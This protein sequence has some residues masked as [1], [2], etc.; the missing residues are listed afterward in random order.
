MSQVKDLVD[1]IDAFI[2]G[3]KDDAIWD[4]I[5]A[6]CIMA[7]WDGLTPI[8]VPLKGA[9]PT[10]NNFVSGDY[11]RKLGLDGDG[12]TKYL[13]TGRLCNDDPQNDNHISVYVTT[14]APGSAI[15]CT[16]TARTA[17]NKTSTLYRYASRANTLTF[18][19]SGSDGFA[20]IS[21]SSSASY[22]WRNGGT[23]GTINVTS[24]PTT[25]DE[26]LLWDE[27]GVSPFSNAVIS[28]YSIGE[29]L[30]LALLDTRVTS[31]MAQLA[32]AINTGLSPV[33]YSSETIDY[34]NA[35]YAAG[36]SL[37]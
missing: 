11:D 33:G 24:Q 22:V 18:G 26:Y 5:K 28:F 19:S 31:L 35:G 2:V 23:G 13:E 17:I 4:A 30:D 25:A 3:C 7:A 20:G 16:G 9:A 32:F 29:A 1:A 8:E 37:A 14:T 12:A 34:V 15:G 6:C 36:G 21:R 27:D 10:N